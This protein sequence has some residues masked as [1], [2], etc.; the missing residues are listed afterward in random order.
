M[1]SSGSTGGGSSMQQ[2]GMSDAGMERPMRRSKK[3]M[4]SSRHSKMMH[5]RR[6]KKMMRSQGT[7]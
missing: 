2:G 6:H 5:S 1:G 3:M 7:M 4:R